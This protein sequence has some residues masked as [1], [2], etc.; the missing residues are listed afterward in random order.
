MNEEFEKWW[1]E[2][3]ASGDADYVAHIKGV[4]LKAWE[5]GYAS[6]TFE[7]QREA[8]ESW[9]EERKKRLSP[10]TNK[11]TEEEYAD[12]MRHAR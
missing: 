1:I 9:L 3:K 4:A 11:M 8:M 10:D 5:A 6:G 2:N 12:W 7:P